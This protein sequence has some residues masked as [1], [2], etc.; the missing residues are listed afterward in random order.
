LK[1]IKDH[2]SWSKCCQCCKDH[3][4]H[5][6]S[7]HLEFRFQL[8]PLLQRF[9]FNSCSNSHAKS[10]VD[11]LES[12]KLLHCNGKRRLARILKGRLDRSL[13]N[14]GQLIFLEW[15]DTILYRSFLSPKL[16]N[17]LQPLQHFRISAYCEEDFQTSTANMPCYR[18]PL[19]TL[20]NFLT[21]LLL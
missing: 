14:L 5:R 2:Y 20:W 9:L 16:G 19:L 7:Y 11:I 4:F 17:H 6:R 12:N 8:P 3:I 10:V 18:S 15:I 1:D 21:A 13:K